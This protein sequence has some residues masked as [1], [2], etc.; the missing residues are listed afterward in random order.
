MP[1]T[2]KKWICHLIWAML[3]IPTTGWGQLQLRPNLTVTI[4]VQNVPAE[5]QQRLNGKYS[6]SESGYLTIWKIGAVKVSG[7]TTKQAAKK[8]G[9]TFK[10]ARIF[11][12]ADF[13]VIAPNPRINR[14][15]LKFTIGGQ[16]KKPG[17][18]NW[19]AGLTLQNAIQMAGGRA[20]N[21]DPGRVTLIRNG[22][23][24]VF[25][26]RKPKHSK[27]KIYNKDLIEVPKETS[28]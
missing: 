22:I 13:E 14:V 26:L 12:K 19:K 10:A 15:P 24:Y 2:A 4:R 25:D 21:A 27:I 16:V 18:K 5:E 8:I 6:I 20:P 28:D 23:K 7:L 1:P 3:L 11:E 9:D 17:L